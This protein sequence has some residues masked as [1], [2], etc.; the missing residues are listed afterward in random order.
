MQLIHELFC[1]NATKAKNKSCHAYEWVMWRMWKGHVTHVDTSCNSHVA[2]IHAS[3][4]MC[5]LILISKYKYTS[6]YFVCVYKIVYMYI[7][8]YIYMY[9]CWDRNICEHITLIHAHTFYICTYI[10]IYTYI[11]II[12]NTST[13]TS[14]HAHTTTSKSEYATVRVHVQCASIRFSDTRTLW[15]HIL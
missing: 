3:Y 7:H 12:K 1:T 15:V 11:C 14:T 2:H 9:E 4:A 8:M 10:Y 13:A 6:V 5:R